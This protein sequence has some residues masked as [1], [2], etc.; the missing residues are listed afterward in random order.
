[1]EFTYEIQTRPYQ[2]AIA[3][4]FRA[5]VQDLPQ[6]FQWAYRLIGQYVAEMGVVHEG[7]VFAAYYNMDM[8][9]MDVEAGFP[10]LVAL[11]ARGDLQPREIAGGSFAVCHYTGPYDAMPP[12]YE[13]LKKFVK[14]EGYSLD[15]SQP[16]YEW[17]FNGPNEV[18]PKD[19]RTDIVL[20]LLPSEEPA[21]S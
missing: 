8:Q 3:L 20:P 11:P 4:R 17:Y 21:R 2:A 19:L 12:V 10:L 14:E 6:Q 15:S 1:M 9:D 18:M 16:S 13:A 7:P 5:P